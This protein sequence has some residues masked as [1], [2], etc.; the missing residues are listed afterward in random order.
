MTPRPEFDAVGMAKTLVRVSRQGALATLM[1]RGGDP[2][3]SLVNVATAADGAPILLISRLAVHTRN[4]LADGR[5]SLMLDDRRAANPF[6]ALRIMFNGEAVET[7][8]ESVAR[9]YLS[10]QPEAEPFAHFGDFSFFVLRP[11]Y[12]HVVAG[13]GRVMNLKPDEFLTD[14]SGADALLA[15]EAE[16]VAHLNA[17]HA[18]AL[19]LHASRL[20]GASAGGWRCVG[21]DPEGLELQAGTDLLRLAFPERVTDPAALRKALKTLADRAR[22]IS[23]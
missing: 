17:D 13:F 20:L 2:Y 11:K 18:E 21:C 9:R 10:R 3:C 12:V 8:D 4:I 5:I 15:A 14:L 7:E 16:I 22:A 19:N 23:Q 6:D 1:Q